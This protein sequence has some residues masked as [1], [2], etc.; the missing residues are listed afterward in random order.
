MFGLPFVGAGAWLYLGQEQYPPVVG[1]PFAAFGLFIITVGVYVHLISPGEL[2]T[3]GDEAIVAKRHPTQRVATAKIGLGLPLLI[4][5]VYLLYFTYVPYLYPTFTLII[6]LYLFSVGV[7]TY[8]TNTLTT[9]YVTTE[10][11]LKEY[12]FLSLVRQEVPRTKIR[13]VQERKSFLETVAGLGNVL[14]A[15]GQGRSLEVQMRN[16]QRPE[17]FADEIR[18]L[19]TE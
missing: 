7:Y 10:R 17:E 5:T 6:G 1:L 19:V 12:R 16:I 2:R 3:N 11:V 9:Y 14:V 18:D 4:V 15:S 8:W 13:G